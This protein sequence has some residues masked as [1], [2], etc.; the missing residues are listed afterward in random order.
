M[1]ESL[2]RIKKNAP[3]ERSES[4]LLPHE[5]EEVKESAFRS[6]ILSTLHENFVAQL[7]D[8]GFEEDEIRSIES[9]IADMSYE[10]AVAVFGTPASI[11]QRRFKRLLA[12]VRTGSLKAGSIAKQLL[13]DARAKGFG[14]GFHNSQYEVQPDPKSGDWLIRPTQQDHRDGD[15]PRAYFA[16]SYKTLYRSKYAMKY[17]YIVRTIDEHTKSDGKWSRTNALSVIDEV[18]LDRIDKWVNEAV[19]NRRNKKES[20]VS[21]KEDA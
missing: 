5:I 18:P 20:D 4:L 14:I 17:L 13:D 8:A 11:S 6:I 2:A 12:E 10:D 9:S 21:S 1:K 19:A 16:T 3:E 7:D 15:L